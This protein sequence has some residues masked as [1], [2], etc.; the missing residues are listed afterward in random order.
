MVYNDQTQQ[1][2]RAPET[3]D[4]PDP[5]KGESTEKQERQEKAGKA[6][7]LKRRSETEGEEPKAKKGSIASGSEKVKPVELKPA[8]EVSTASPEEKG[9]D[10]RKARA[11]AEESEK[12]PHTPRSGIVLKKAEEVQQ[13]DA[14]EKAPHRESSDEADDAELAENLQKASSVAGTSRKGQEGSEGPRSVEG[15]CGD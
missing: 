14:G 6:V 9:E 8:T 3:A 1:W 10:A 5:G 15:M 13:H 7:Q 12:R 2:E 4:I 11:S